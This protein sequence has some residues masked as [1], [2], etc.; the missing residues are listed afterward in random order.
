MEFLL[1]MKTAKEQF[2]EIG[3]AMGF[4]D[5]ERK[6]I[7]KDTEIIS[8]NMDERAKE[9]HPVDSEFERRGKTIPRG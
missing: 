8:V 6:K 5:A 3:K 2:E 7:S 4:N 1:I 9:I